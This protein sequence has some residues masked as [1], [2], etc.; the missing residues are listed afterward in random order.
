M[1]FHMFFS[2]SDKVIYSCLNILT[3][4]KYWE[5]MHLLFSFTQYTDSMAMTNSVNKF[6]ILILK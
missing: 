1:Q 3:D 5:I 6:T 4:D 2:Y